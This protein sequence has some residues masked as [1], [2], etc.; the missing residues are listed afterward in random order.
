MFT[1]LN[2]RTKPTKLQRRSER[3]A[4]N[5]RIGPKFKGNTGFSV[6]SPF[7]FGA[8]LHA[9]TVVSL[10][11]GTLFN[12]WIEFLEIWR[13][14]PAVHVFLRFLRGFSSILALFF[15]FP[16]GLGAFWRILQKIR[17]EI[18]GFHFNTLA[19]FACLLFSCV[20]LSFGRV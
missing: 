17:F 4:N 15:G 10:H 7:T 18:A 8:P 13:F 2:N 16:A 14:R 11:C 9:N 20:S 3:K 19:L 5:H 6:R 1:A 12:L